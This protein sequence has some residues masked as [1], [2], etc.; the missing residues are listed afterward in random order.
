M[1]NQESE[2]TWSLG[3]LCSLWMVAAETRFSRGKTGKLHEELDQKW[4]AW[5]K[6][7]VPRPQI[8]GSYLKKLRIQP[9]QVHALEQ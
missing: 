3:I 1:R 8:V 9:S 7:M 2:A 6:T 5:T 4:K